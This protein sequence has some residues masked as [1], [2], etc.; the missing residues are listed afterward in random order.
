MRTQGREKRTRAPKRKG[1]EGFVPL[2]T[3][4]ASS[5]PAHEFPQSSLKKL[6]WNYTQTIVLE[7]SVARSGE[8]LR[9]AATSLYWQLSRS[10]THEPFYFLGLGRVLQRYYASVD[11][12]RNLEGKENWT[13]LTQCSLHQEWL[14]PVRSRVSRL[15]AWHVP[16]WR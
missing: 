9:H 3:G 4:S 12:R 14:F 11:I 10:R 7:R 8:I 16:F 6:C 5:P 15:D 1:D 2:P 13:G